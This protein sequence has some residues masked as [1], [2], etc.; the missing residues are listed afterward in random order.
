MVNVKL[1]KITL[2]R[3]Y[4]YTVDGDVNWYSYYGKQ[5]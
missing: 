3:E 4:L 1:K 2:K 5:C